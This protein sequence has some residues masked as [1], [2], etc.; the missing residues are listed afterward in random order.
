MRLTCDSGDLAAAL[1]GVMRAVS[2]RT[3]L[4]V[5]GTVLLEA[6]GEELLLT[7]TNLELT[8][9]RR[10]AADVAV[11]GGVAIPARLLAEFS[12]AIPHER[13]RLDLEQPGSRLRLRS[14]TFTSEIHGVPAGEFPPGAGAAGGSRLALPAQ[15]L[16]G[17]I[18]DTLVA[19]STDEAR[20][21]LTGVRLEIEGSRLVL[22]ATDGHRMAVR[23]VELGVGQSLRTP[24]IIVPARTMAEV[25]RLFR[26]TDGDLEVAV[27]AQ[28]NEVFFEA[29]GAEIASRVIDGAYPDHRRLVPTRFATRVTV[30]AAELSGRLRA[31]APFAHSSA[32]VVRLAV[33]QRS[34]VLSAATI[35]VGS[36]ETEL[37]AAV[38]G[39]ETRVAFNARFLLDCPAL[40]TEE[41]V[42]LHLQGPMGACVVRRTTAPVSTDAAQRCPGERV[43]GGYRRDDYTYLFMPIR[44]PAQPEVRAA[45]G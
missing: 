43:R 15:Q 9:R 41:R 39:G 2:S 27:S 44:Y 40:S 19:A 23:R 17:A 34:I 38:A 8:I 42:E 6:T 28:G 25:V 1:G 26:S 3:S 33:M 29:P 30:S 7:G 5:L 16:L 22:A 24:G 14:D 10:I 4:P 32:N 20:P 21:A 45:A 18:T 12:G 37:E 11:D 36:A 13:L 31:L 35:D